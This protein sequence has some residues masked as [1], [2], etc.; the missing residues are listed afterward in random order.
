MTPKE[1]TAELKELKLKKVEFAEMVGLKYRT[2]QDWRE[3]ANPVPAWV[4]SWLANY[5]LAEKFKELQKIYGKTSQF[6]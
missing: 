4:D 2:I 5:Q 6:A 3:N 1:F